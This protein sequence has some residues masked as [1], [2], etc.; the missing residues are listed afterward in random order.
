M[1]MS[2]SQRSTLR[3]GAVML[4]L[5]AV[6]LAAFA[7]FAPSSSGSD[8]EEVDDPGSIALPSLGLFGGSVM[9][10]GDVPADGVG[11]S[12]VDCTLRTAD[13]SEQSSAKISELAV[14]GRGDTV[15]LDGTTLRPLLE[16]RGYPSGS[17]LACESGS[18]PQPAAV[19]SSS[20]FGSLGGLVR[21]FA[22]FMA[23]VCLVL[24]G[25]ALLVLRS[26]ARTV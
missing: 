25:V 17:T 5:A 20:T 3:L 8:V 6:V 14:A 15:E 10:Y 24:G 21:V 23:V 7:L 4:L 2:Q 12:G 18:F 22:G 13:G 19:G 26:P 16:V 1:R 9:L 11:T